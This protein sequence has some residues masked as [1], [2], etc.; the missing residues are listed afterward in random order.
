MNYLL[1]FV[2]GKMYPHYLR[3]AN[4]KVF[5]KISPNNQDEHLI[6]LMFASVLFDTFFNKTNSL[7]LFTSNFFFTLVIFFCNVYKIVQ[8]KF[9][10]WKI[11]T[12]LKYSFTLLLRNKQKTLF[13]FFYFIYVWVLRTSDSWT[14]VSPSNYI[15][16]CKNKL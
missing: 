15:I 3:N 2:K 11:R 5:M 16:I 4:T 14:G 12:G 9:S 13:N 8:N 6:I 1:S 10:H 7:I